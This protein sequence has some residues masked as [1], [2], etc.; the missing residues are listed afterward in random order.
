MDAS[1][2]S[3]LFERSRG[4]DR[5]AANDLYRAAFPRLRRIASSLLRLERP[6]HTLQ[7]TALVGEAFLK[8][9][10]LPAGVMGEGHFFHIAARAMK[11][12]LIDHARV[13]GEAKRVPIESIPEF[14][15]A[16]GDS[17]DTEVLVAVRAVFDK[18]R[19]MD[20]RTAATV[21]MRG[22]E[23]RTIQEVAEIQ[24]REAWRVRADY[25][26][27]VEWMANRLRRDGFQ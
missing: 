15:T 10:K 8:L 6:A 5:G 21:W 23:G 4:G 20:Q 7:P 9:H 17:H 3:F 11:Q 22:V 14:L 25:D 1:T 24:K 16:E 27:G 26:F 13:R 19:E 2:F 18:L 12:V